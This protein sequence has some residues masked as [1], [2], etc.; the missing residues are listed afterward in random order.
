MTREAIV[1]YGDAVIAEVRR[2]NGAIDTG[3]G[4]RQA[5]VSAELLDRLRVG[6]LDSP[7]TKNSLKDYLR[8]RLSK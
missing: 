5:D 2:L 7:R 1:N 3:L 6:L 8:D 4:E